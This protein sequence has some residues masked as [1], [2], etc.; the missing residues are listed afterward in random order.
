MSN[1]APVWSSF[2]VGHNDTAPPCL[3][4]HCPWGAIKFGQRMLPVP[5]QDFFLGLPMMDGAMG[6]V[7]YLGPMESLISTPGIP[8]TPAAEVGA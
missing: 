7:Q 4:A 8:S 6:N 5:C 3:P 1:P 2:P